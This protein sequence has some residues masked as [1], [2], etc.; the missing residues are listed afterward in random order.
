MDLMVDGKEEVHEI[1]KQIEE[2]GGGGED[3]QSGEQVGCCHDG[4]A[5]NVTKRGVLTECSRRLASK[6]RQERG[7][8]I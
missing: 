6:P 2:G 1:E 3:R 4:S 7:E 5:G 8:R